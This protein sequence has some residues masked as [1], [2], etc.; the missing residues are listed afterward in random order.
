MDPVK[1]VVHYID[2]RI[3]KGFTQSFVPNKPTF[4]IWPIG[5]KVPTE[6]IEVSVKDLKGVFFVRD[7]AG[8]PKYKE[9]K[10]FHEGAKILG[11]KVEV[12]FKDGEVIVGSTLDYEPGRP[13]FFLYPSDP[14]WNIL[15][16]FVLS[17]AVAKV[18][19]AIQNL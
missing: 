10:I 5:H 9:L 4:N 16:V 18:S 13:W 2:G 17:Q 11:R 19:Y 14:H 12:T 1:I 7:F 3:I 8:N 15:R 6:N